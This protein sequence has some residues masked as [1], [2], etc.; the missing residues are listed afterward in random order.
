MLAEGY[1][2]NFLVLDGD[3]LADFASV[4]RINLRVKAGTPI[5]GY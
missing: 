2:A 1:E 3:P 5:A 4:R